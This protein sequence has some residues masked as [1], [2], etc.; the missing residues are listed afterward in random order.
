MNTWYRKEENAGPGIS[1]PPPA[2][3]RTLDRQ[4]SLWYAMIVR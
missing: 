1:N 4:G 2:F 3:V